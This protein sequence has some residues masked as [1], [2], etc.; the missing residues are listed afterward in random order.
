LFGSVFV[1]ADAFYSLFPCFASG[2]FR[3]L[4]IKIIRMHYRQGKIDEIKFA[5]KETPMEDLL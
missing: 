1:A 5:P 3:E 4:V 2:Q